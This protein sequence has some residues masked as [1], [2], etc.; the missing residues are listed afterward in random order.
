MYEVK[1]YLNF[2]CDEANYAA[3]WYTQTNKKLLSCSMVTVLTMLIQKI[4]L[5]QRSFA[6]T[7]N[8]FGMSGKKTST[9]KLYFHIEKD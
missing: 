5:S 3:K 2:V 7:E 6:F 4:C 9:K 8:C 1:G